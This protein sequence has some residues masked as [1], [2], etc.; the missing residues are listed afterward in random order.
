MFELPNLETRTKQ[1]KATAEGKITHLIDGDTYEVLEKAVSIAALDCPENSTPD[2]KR[3]TKF[4]KRFENQYA[5]CRLTS[6]ATY[7]RRVGY[8]NIG[9][10]DFGKTIMDNTS[11]KLCRKYDVW[12]IY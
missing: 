4:A 3:V 7:D 2:G 5:V 9:G 8:C 11:C 12:N 1:I 6:A 10:V